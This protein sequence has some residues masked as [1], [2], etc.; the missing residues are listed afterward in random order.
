MTIIAFLSII[1]IGT[2]CLLF[3]A[4][5][6]IKEKDECISYLYG[7]LNE[8]Q[9]ELSKCN[10]YNLVVDSLNS[11]ISFKTAECDSLQAN[12]DVANFKLNRIDYYNKVAA[13][14]NNIKF[15]RGWINRVIN[16]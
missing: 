13:K 15:L 8:L 1:L 16:D 7:G 2:C 12:L 5:E 10:N 4:R 9:E 3:D 11:I 6:S 14:G